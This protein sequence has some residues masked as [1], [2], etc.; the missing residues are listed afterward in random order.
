M[1]SPGFEDV[2]SSSAFFG[3]CRRMLNLGLRLK[4]S[5]SALAGPEA[6]SSSGLSAVR[7]GLGFRV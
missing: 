1:A 4:G 5:F 7:E 6:W 3:S 2:Q